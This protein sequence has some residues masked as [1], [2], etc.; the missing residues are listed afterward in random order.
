MWNCLGLAQCDYAK[1]SARSSQ[2]QLTKPHA[3][4][5]IATLSEWDDGYDFRAWQIS[6]NLK[7]GSL[8]V[9]ASACCRFLLPIFSRYSVLFRFWRLILLSILLAVLL[10]IPS[11]RRFLSV[12][13][14]EMLFKPTNELKIFYASECECFWN[15]LQRK[16]WSGWGGTLTLAQTHEHTHAHID[17]HQ[18]RAMCGWESKACWQ[19][20]SNF[21]V[22]VL[23][24]AFSSALKFLGAANWISFE[25]FSLIFICILLLDLE[26]A[27]CPVIFSF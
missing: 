20:H 21:V 2:D 23:G 10:G 8:A 3:H 18:S 11:N 6:T 22:L 9:G 1:G 5:N 12:P 16:E 26:I 14:I 25:C 13:P 27:F 4:I 15:L 24:I 7:F 19:W 17:T